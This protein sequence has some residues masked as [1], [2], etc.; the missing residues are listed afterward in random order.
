MAENHREDPNVVVW[1]E[2][3]TVTWVVEIGG[4]SEP[5]ENISERTGL[6]L[7]AA[8]G[9]DIVGSSGPDLVVEWVLQISGDWARLGLVPS[10]AV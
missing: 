10:A 2:V 5:L 6:R 7:L 4:N 1:L 3:T 9:D 8:V